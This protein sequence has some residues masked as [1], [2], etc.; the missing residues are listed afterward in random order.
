[1][2]FEQELNIRYNDG[3]KKG[4]EESRLETAAAMKRKEI[5]IEVIEECTGLTKEQIEEL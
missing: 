3:L 5:P 1:M 4:R 2:T